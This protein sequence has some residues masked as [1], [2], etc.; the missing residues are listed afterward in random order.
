MAKY[1]P[2]M[3]E[4]AYGGQGVECDGLY[5]LSP[6]SGTI[7]RCGL[8]GAGVSLWA[9]LLRSKLLPVWK[10]LEYSASSLQM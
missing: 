5:M 4:P 10:Y 2:H 6:G 3:F 7:W 8:V 9:W 1:G